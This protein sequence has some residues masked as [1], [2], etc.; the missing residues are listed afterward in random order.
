MICKLFYNKAD[1]RYINKDKIVNN[2]YVF[3]EPVTRVIEEQTVDQFNIEF[4]DESS[5]T[6][7]VLKLSTDSN[8]L[9]ANYLYLV[10]FHRY[11]FIND[12]KVARGY[13]ILY[14]HVDVLTSFQEEIMNEKVILERSENIYNLYQ[15]DP[16]F[17]LM[18]YTR[19]YTKFFPSGFSKSYQNFLL[20]VVGKTTGSVGGE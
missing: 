10:D 14:C 19:E 12:I 7:P 16:E 9:T 1:K 13:L 15:T 5:Y 6:D 17:R 20:T 18:N 3:L 4:L 8:A 11:Y 2:N